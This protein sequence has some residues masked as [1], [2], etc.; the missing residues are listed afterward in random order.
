MSDWLGELGDRLTPALAGL[1]V[2]G[3]LVVGLAILVFAVRYLLSV[4]WSHRRPFTQNHG[5][6][7]NAL[8]LVSSTEI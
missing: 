1:Y 3:W 4:F 8:W 7:V 6:R 5:H 2:V